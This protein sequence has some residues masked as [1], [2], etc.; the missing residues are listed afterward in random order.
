MSPATNAASRAAG[1]LLG[2]A[3]LLVACSP[4]PNV[5]H[6]YDA[7]AGDAFPD[8][9][10]PVT[11]PA[12][13]AIVVTDS[14]SD[15]L[16]LVD[17]GTGERFASFPVGRDPVSIDGPHHLAVNVAARR[18]FTALSYPVLATGG[19][20]ASHGSSVQA[21]YAQVLSLD[22]F[23]ILGQV[24]V[25]N[26]PGDIVL[27]E[28]GKRL[29][30]S[31]FDLVRALE[32]AGDLDKQRATLAI[33]DPSTLEQPVPPAPPRIDVCIA[34]HAVALSRPDAARAYVACNGEDSIAVVDLDAAKV[35]ERIPVAAGA[36]AQGN[37]QYG[38]YS[39]VLSPDGKTLAIGNQVSRDVSFLDIETMA[40]MPERTLSTQGTPF[41]PA[42]SADG[43]TLYVTT[44]TPNAVL[45]IDFSADNAELERRDFAA[46]ECDL[47]HVAEIQGDALLVVCEGDHVAP[48]R[49]LFLEPD[50]LTTRHTTEVGVYP[51]AMA[52]VGGAR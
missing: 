24:R 37:P 11:Y 30:V 14:Y 32:N 6:E 44:Q 13:G 5:V 51:D 45:A 35:L 21:G 29:V 34:P 20:H 27:S 40:M 28:D 10:Q 4:E 17:L 1:A 15:T 26:N 42:W 25:D 50:T 38:P 9:L 16:S 31:H 33:I 41:F 8:R 47:P 39:A 48:G 3:A 18:L 23:R 52:R 19:P 2:L 49:V 46:G 36:S 22:D 43:N 12:A 7:Y